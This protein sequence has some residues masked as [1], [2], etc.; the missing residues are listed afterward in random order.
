MF[1]FL[2]EGEFR[3]LSVVGSE[4]DRQGDGFDSS[5]GQIDVEA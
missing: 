2:D 4:E 5:E 1:D 3:E